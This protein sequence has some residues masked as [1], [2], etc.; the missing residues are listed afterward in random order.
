MEVSLSAR[1]SQVLREAI[2]PRYAE[3][4]CGLVAAR[5]RQNCGGAPIGP[6]LRSI[7][8]IA[9]GLQRTTQT[10]PQLPLVDELITTIK[11]GQVE[12]VENRL[13]AVI[14]TQAAIQ[15]LQ[16]LNQKLG[17]DQLV[18]FSDEQSLS[19]DP[20]RPTLF[21]S[22]YEVVFPAGSNLLDIRTWKRFTLPFN[23]SNSVTV[24]ARVY[25]AGK[26]C[27]GHF[28]AA[29]T[30]RFQCQTVRVVQSGVVELYLS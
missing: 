26:T 10:A 27:Q 13:K 20:A 6:G 21:S 24:S 18:L 12:R 30:M 25:L 29:M 19:V 1:N 5:S 11:D 23:M 22:S 2:C 7:V 15:S 14:N 17:L 16:D 8:R 28:E 4:S 9:G 3:R